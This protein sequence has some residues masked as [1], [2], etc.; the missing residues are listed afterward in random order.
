MNFSHI[1]RKFAFRFLKALDTP[2]ALT[3]WLLIEHEEWGQLVNLR[4][5]PA[6]FD[7]PETFF[8]A[9][10]ATELFRKTEDLPSTGIDLKG[11]AIKAFHAAEMRCAESNLRLSRYLHN[12]PFEDPQEIRIANFLDNVKKRVA[13]I[14]GN[15]PPD[16]N[17]RFGPGATFSTSSHASTVCDKMQNRPTMTSLADPFLYYWKET[18]WFRGLAM[19]RPDCTQP[20]LVR[21]NRFTSVPKDAT[22]NRGIA[23]EPEINGFY[24]LAVHEEMRKRLYRVGLDLEHGQALHRRMA[25]EASSKG[26]FC[27]IDLSSA[28]DTICKVLVELLLP[29]QWYLV[30][31]SLRSPLTK[32]GEEWYY[33]EKFSS[34]GNGFTFEL[35]TLVFA[36]I[37][38]E[39]IA[40]MGGPASFGNEVLVYGDD[41][42]CRTEYA[43]GVLAVLKFCGFEPN[44]RKTAT[45]GYFRESCGGDYFNGECVIPFRLRKLPSH[46][47]EWIA[48][49]NGLRRVSLERYGVSLWESIR[50]L[51]HDQIPLPVRRCKGPVCLGDIVIHTDDENLWAVRRAPGCRQQ[52]ELL[53]YNP[54]TRA[55]PL[56]RWSTAVQMSAA[57]YGVPS[58]GVV[59]RSSVSGFVRRWTA[60]P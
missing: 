3:V 16:L 8:R 22:K 54:V 51:I 43:Q 36:C 29:Q 15:L 17:G 10:Q 38:A 56:L 1:H 28:S 40:Q 20:S 23:I 14:L 60:Y 30:L 12:G 31:A 42:I 44:L 26:N 50:S 19:E 57:L 47:S 45:S 46:P 58:E 33:L 24:Q 53:T 21:G 55:V 48:L 27:T 6:H 49:S 32:V 37:T 11:E 52:R 35:E 59:R 7:G 34:M 25:R 13:S 9:Y 18:A 39:A 4:V 5:D 2:R 41:I